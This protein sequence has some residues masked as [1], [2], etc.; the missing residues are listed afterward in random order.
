MSAY[1]VQ[2]SGCPSRRQWV[3]CGVALLIVMVLLLRCFGPQWAY[4]SVCAY[5]GRVKYTTRKL[6]PWS[7][8][9]WWK[10]ES[11]SETPF[12]KVLHSANQYQSSVPACWL[13]AHGGGARMGTGTGNI[14]LPIVQDESIVRFI[15]DLSKFSDAETLEKWRS[16]LLD[17]ERAEYCATIIR[18]S[19]APGSQQGLQD[20]LSMHSALLSHVLRAEL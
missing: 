11:V 7:Q 6:I 9:T 2:A 17:P 13:F 10:A 18:E 4:I 16:A 14:L 1:L 5:S 12:S 3:L 19:Y 8:V 15:K 20:W